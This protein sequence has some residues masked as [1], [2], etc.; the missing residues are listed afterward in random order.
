MLY[1]S[2]YIPLMKQEGGLALKLGEKLWLGDSTVYFVVNS[3]G[4]LEL[5]STSIAITGTFTLGPIDIAAGTQTVSNPLFD[6]TVTWNAAGVTFEA[7][8]IAVT[9]TASAAASLLA[10]LTVGGATKFSVRKDGG[11]VTAGKIIGYGGAAITDGQ[12]LIGATAT[13]DFTA[14]TLTGTSNQVSVANAGGTITLSLPQSIHSAAKPTF[15][16]L[17]LTQGTATLP[18]PNLSGTVTWNAGAET[19]TGLFLNVT[20]T[21]SAAASM[22]MDLQIGGATK[23]NVLKSGNINCGTIGVIGGTVTADDPCLEMDQTWNNAGVVFTAIDLDVI[24]TASDAASMFMN[25][26]LS[27]VSKFSVRKDGVC[28]AVGFSGP[29][30]GNVTGNASGSSGSC[31]GAALTAGTVTGYV[32]G[33]AFNIGTGTDVT[34]TYDGTDNV[35]DELI[36]AACH[37]TN[38]TAT[39]SATCTE[40]RVISVEGSIV[41]D[42]EVDDETG[43]GICRVGAAGAATA[44]IAVGGTAPAIADGIIGINRPLKSCTGGR[45]GEMIDSVNVSGVIKTVAAG[46]AFTNQ[47]ANDSI[48]FVSSAAGD[49]Q[50]LIM[51]GTTNGTDT[52][53]VE[54]KALNGTTGVISTKLD[55]GEMLGFE[56]SSAAVG[57][58]TI[59]ETSGGLTITTIAADAS[60]KGVETVA[61]GA[62]A[63]AFNGI[64]T[65]VSDGATTKQIGV[66]GT[67]VDYTVLTNNSKNLNSTTAVALATAMNIVT[68]VLVGDL[69]AARAVTVKV[70]AT[71]D[72]AEMRIAQS[73]AAASAKDSTL[74][75]IIAKGI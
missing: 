47:P 35:W 68:K 19:F 14:G 39:A 34:L 53:V 72:D 10:N 5:V 3:A 28:T 65:I 48:T 56:L 60:S 66:V 22:L 13:A 49:T 36:G 9:N 55:W 32:D 37:S 30:T 43:M 31:T 7:F 58:I 64:P 71:E 26:K 16:S 6:G 1:G 57:T 29:L 12:V 25:F 38:V 41:A 67:G 15:G 54:T 45:V 27:T 18:S 52:I 74:R 23:F 69:E 20:D 50:N 51:Y 21:A 70:R 75:V 33:V 8:K 4:A 42:A 17:T 11:I 2:D 44:T 73:L 61:A 40:G 63:R 24:S 62:A 59:K 46:A